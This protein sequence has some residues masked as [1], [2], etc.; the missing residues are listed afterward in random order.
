[1]SIGLF[2]RED[3]IPEQEDALTPNLVSLDWFDKPV[4]FWD[5]Q[6]ERIQA[7]EDFK[8]LKWEEF[9]WFR[10]EALKIIK[11]ALLYVECLIVTF[12]V[13][14]LQYPVLL[15]LAFIYILYRINKIKKLLRL[16]MTFYELK[17]RPAI[18]RHRIYNSIN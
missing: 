1:M 15:F 14:I 9:F 13:Y 6:Q 10:K 12:L 18:A 11:M 8:E 4:S 16:H 7:V 17:M 3:I 5:A 2:D